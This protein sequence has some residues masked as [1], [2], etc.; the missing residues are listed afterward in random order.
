M[1][2]IVWVCILL[3]AAAIVLGIVRAVTAKDS[4]SRAVVGDLV[5]FSAIGI[6]TLIAMLG[7][8]SIVL[9]VILLSSLLGILSTVALSRILTRGHR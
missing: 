6:L 9:D 4:G 8:L 2:I 3:L 7:G 1:I 5:Y